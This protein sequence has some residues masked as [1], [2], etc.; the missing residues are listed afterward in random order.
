MRRT[1]IGALV[2]M[3]SALLGLAARAEEPKGITPQMVRPD[4][5]MPG[6]PSS[7]VNPSKYGTPS[8]PTVSTTPVKTEDLDG[9]I[10]GL[11]EKLNEDFTELNEKL[12]TANDQIK[13][14]Q[15]QLNDL[16]SK[17]AV[18]TH[19][20]V[21]PVLDA[22]VTPQNIVNN[23]AFGNVLIPFKIEGPGGTGIQSSQPTATTAPN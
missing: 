7:P 19:N 15:S 12:K 10:L 18:H 1:M 14:L 8:G 6:S 16:Q 9:K 13:Q 17:Y 2:C 11:N 4:Q 20:Y 23:P 3:A 5:K 21:Y 22:W